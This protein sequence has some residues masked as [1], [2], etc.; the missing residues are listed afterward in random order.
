MLAAGI[1]CVA[2]WFRNRTFHC[3]VTA[4]LFLITGIVFLFSDMQI[5]YINP[6]FVWL[7]VFV[8]IA[9]AFWLEW[10]YARRVT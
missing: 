7:I 5:F 10:K 1:G 8:G 3:G 6:L 4:P 2:N 9:V